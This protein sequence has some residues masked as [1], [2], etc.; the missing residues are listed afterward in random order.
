MYTLSIVL[1]LHREGELAAKTIQN[2]RDILET[3]NDW[4][5][6]EIIAV[7][8]NADE[9]T[10]SIVKDNEDL[11]TLVEKVKYK[12]LGA[13]RNHGV[14]CVNNEFIVFA[15]GDDYCSLE[16]LQGLYETFYEHY[17]NKN[18]WKNLSESEH[19]A[20]FPKYLIEFPALF[21]MTYCDSN[22]ILTLNNR[23]S[24]CYH[25]KISIHKSLLKKNIINKNIA[26]YGYEDWDLNNRLLD[27]GVQ[28]KTTEYKLYYR[29]E[30]MQKSLLSKQVD[31]KHIVRNSPIYRYK[32]N[33]EEMIEKRKD[34]QIVEFSKQNLKSK[35]LIN[36]YK[37]VLF[38]EDKVFLEHYNEPYTYREDI[39][40]WSTSNLANEKTVQSK[41]YDELMV[42]LQDKDI[43]YFTPWIGL[44]GAD[45]VFLEYTGAITSTYNA[46]V[47][48]TLAIGSRINRLTVPYLDLHE[49]SESWE[50][51]SEEEQLHILIKV[52]INSNIKVLHV[53]QSNIA[54]KIIKY[55]GEVLEE[56]NVKIIVSLFTPDYDWLNNEYHGYPV[57]YPEIYQYADIVLSDNEFWY[58]FFRRLNNNK[59][60]NFKKLS[61]ST[62]YIESSYENKDTFSKKILWASRICDQKLFGVFEEIINKLP[63]YT[64]IIYG[65]EPEELHNQEILNRLLQKSNVE[66]RGEYQDI[67]ELDLNEFDLYLFTSLFEGIPTIILDMVMGGI[68]I[69]SADVGGISEVLGKEYSLLVK[70]PRNSEEYV[71]K[72]VSFYKQSI[73]CASQ[74]KSIRQY[75]IDV[76]NQHT[77]QSEYQDIMKKVGF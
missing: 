35:L 16:M 71:D 66:F 57:M 72:I 12:D 4:E 17:K 73:Q 18:N 20:I 43:V 40:T 15:D 1:N 55:Y 67:S 64:F 42:F 53:V 14:N 44:G 61:S 77:F 45:K 59:D 3:P 2:L 30:N 54:L 56:Y 75:V 26:P 6:V 31:N 68:P 52:L 46:C 74:M 36:V 37:E 39:T 11:F 23:F 69:V 27:S 10:S 41:I 47:I 49:I 29:R 8:D 33:E 34:C 5:D 9:L 60:F 24:H 32:D 58:N 63:E 7:L 21:Q 19:I 13:S 76:H 62:K 22:D 38:H 28:Y 65:G 25:S 51:I 48:T 50:H 70:E